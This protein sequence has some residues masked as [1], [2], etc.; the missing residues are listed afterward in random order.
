M[1]SP[2]TRLVLTVTLA[3]NRRGL[4]LGRRSTRVHVAVYRWTGGRVGTRMTGLPDARILL[5]DQI[6]AK[7]GVGRTSPLIFLRDNGTPV[8]AASKAGQPELPAWFHNLR[9]HPKTTIQIGP[10]RFRVRARVATEP[11][12]D[13][14][15][16]SFVA[17]FPALESYQRTVGE[18]GI[19]LV[20]LEP[21]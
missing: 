18:R 10:E 13:R 6:G 8:I 1:P 17:I 15:W 9:A 7:S 3:A 20:I 21:R 2:L 16:P 12:R 4:Y 19:P 11:E 5:L 14:L